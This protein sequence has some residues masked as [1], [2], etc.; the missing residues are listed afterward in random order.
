VAVAGSHAYVADEYS[1]LQVVDISNPAAPAIV[2]SVGTPGGAY[3]V[4][5]AG[6]HV[7][8]AASFAGVQVFPAQCPRANPVEISGFEATPV[9]G[10][11]L[12]RWITSLEFNHLG[13][14]VHRS[15]AAEGEYARMTPELLQPPGPHRFL[16]TEVTV[17]TT[18]FY[19]L[20]AVDGTGECCLTGRARGGH[21]CDRAA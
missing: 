7:F 8:V 10:A 15:T 6:S 14:H 20:E 13:F 11:I 17:G 4:A 3:G 5:V 9:P 16:D 12:L 18:Y 2:G 1:G 19:R 21:G